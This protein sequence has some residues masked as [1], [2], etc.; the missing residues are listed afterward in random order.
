MLL[1]VHILKFPHFL[2]LVQMFSLTLHFQT[3]SVS[4]LFAEF[5]IN[6]IIRARNVWNF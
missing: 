1:K 5:K 3:V 2:S 4:V 6:S